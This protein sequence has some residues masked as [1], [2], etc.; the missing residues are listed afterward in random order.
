MEEE[1]L[2]EEPLYF[3]YDTDKRLVYR[4][5]YL[6]IW[7]CEM[8]ESL[9][10]FIVDSQENLAPDFITQLKSG[11]ANWTTSLM[12][13]L[14]CKE[15]DENVEKNDKYSKE[16]SDIILKAKNENQ[17]KLFKEVT[18]D[19]FYNIGESWIIS[20]LLPDKLKQLKTQNMLKILPSLTEMLNGNKTNLFG[21]GSESKT[22]TTLKKSEKE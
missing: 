22:L 16:I 19:F 12:S 11:K 21:G 20:L 18:K 2:L 8:G 3:K 14:F 13:Y 4:Y 7:Q 6:C 15:G 17:Y 9:G 10:R 5:A 1:K